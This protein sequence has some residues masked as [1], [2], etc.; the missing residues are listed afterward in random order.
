[1]PD[2]TFEDDSEA[3]PQ[4]RALI[5]GKQ[6]D[7]LLEQIGWSRLLDPIHVSV[8]NRLHVN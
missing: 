8:I 6:G 4:E 2:K 7:S 3:P 5:A 1:M